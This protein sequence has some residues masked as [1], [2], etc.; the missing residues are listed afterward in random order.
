MVPQVCGHCEQAPV[1]SSLAHEWPPPRECTLTALGHSRVKVTVTVTARQVLSKSGRQIISAVTFV[2]LAHYQT[3]WSRA[4]GDQGV[5]CTTSE[6][7]EPEGN[8]RGE[9]RAGEDMKKD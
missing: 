1:L 2:C 4:V 8:A 7:G 3:S 6:A 9:E 5:S